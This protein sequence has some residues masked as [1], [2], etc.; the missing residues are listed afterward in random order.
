MDIAQLAASRID[1]RHA[2]ADDNPANNLQIIADEITRKTN[3]VFVVFMNN[4]GIRYSHPNENLIGKHFTGGDEM[5][6]LSGH[7]YTSRAVGVS[8]PSI[9]AFVPVYDFQNNQAGAVSVGFWQPD[10]KATIAKVTK[11]FYVVIPI[12]ILTA[13]LTSLMLSQNIKLSLFG[14]EP[15]EIA[16]L[17]QERESMLES[18]REGIIAINSEH[19][20]TVINNA[21]RRLLPPDIETNDQLISDVL[22]ESKL[23]RVMES[24]IPEYDQPMMINNTAVLANR[25]PLIIDGK[26]VGAI[27]TFRDLTDMNRVAEE[28]TGVK[29][30]VN[31]LRAKTHEF[32]NKMHVVSGL[33]QLGDYEEAQKFITKLTDKEQS[34]VGFI[35]DNIRNAAAAGLIV[36]KSS[37]AEESHIDLYIDKHTNLQYLPE[38][39]GE[40]SF[41]VVI[42]NLLENAFH[43]VTTM[44]VSRKKVDLLIKQDEQQITIRVKDYGPGIDQYVLDRIYTPGITTKA[45]GTGYGLYNTLNRVNMAQGTINYETS[46]NGTTFTVVIPNELS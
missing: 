28:L 20:V 13:L 18:V 45:T 34:L 6:S 25:V 33:I 8:G 41:A 7:A 10:I 15:D 27:A 36:G 43:A 4:E 29:K 5:P 37:V 38:H 22:P 16:K 26:A 35:L 2:Y 17:L 1:A 44:P 11:I 21:A 12:G 31:A 42:G 23:P 46:D 19:K 14:M 24:K 40:N 30:V 9:R 3:A 39:F 32:M